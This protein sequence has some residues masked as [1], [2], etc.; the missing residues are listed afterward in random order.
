MNRR[1][2]CF[3]A[4]VAFVFVSASMSMAENAIL[5]S[6]ENQ[7]VTMEMMDDTA[8]DSVRGTAVIYGASYPSVTT[9]FKEHHV[10]YKG[11]G[12]DGDYRSYNYIGNSWSPYNFTVSY[13]GGALLPAGTYLAAGDDWLVDRT[14][15]PNSWNSYYAELAEYHYQVLYPDTGNP[16]PYA[17]HASAWNRPL[18]TFTW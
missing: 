7:G 5:A 2:L 15:S 12:A 14:S 4:A 13:E 11:F 8:L 6:L 17:F 9:G 16:S 3:L 18:T 1:I 10:T